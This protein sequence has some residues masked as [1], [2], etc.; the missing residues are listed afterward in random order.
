MQPGPGTYDGASSIGPQVSSA[1]TSNAAF[2]FGSGTR[3][4]RSKGTPGGPALVGLS[5]PTPRS[6]CVLARAYW[7]YGLV[8]RPS[9]PHVLAC[10]RAR[11]K[12][13]H[14]APL[15]GGFGFSQRVVA[16]SVCRAVYLSPKHERS[17]AGLLS[18]G[19][20]A[21]TMRGSMGRQVCRRDLI[22]PPCINH[23]ESIHND[24]LLRA[25]THTRTSMR[26]VSAVVIRSRAMYQRP[27]RSFP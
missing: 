2:G 13:T 9:V 8:E 21:Y 11:A 24:L 1:K 6:C 14:C 7:T 22:V 25:R 26:R 19:P 16:H 23:N 18:P 17:M 12:G 3:Q 10:R 5:A 15:D 20:C 4:G 27:T